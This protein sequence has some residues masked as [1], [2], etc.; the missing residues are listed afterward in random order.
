VFG[1]TW[2]IFCFLVG[3]AVYV[4]VTSRLPYGERDREWLARAGGW[5]GIFLVAYLVFSW[6]VLFG[7]QAVH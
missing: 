3:E 7:W 2:I 6:I 5:F 4:G 1:P